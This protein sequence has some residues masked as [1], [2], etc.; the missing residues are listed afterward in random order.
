MRSLL[1]STRESQGQYQTELSKV[2]GQHETIAKLESTHLELDEI[3]NE[4]LTQISEAKV[5]SQTLK[6][7][8]D[9]ENQRARAEFLALHGEH[10]DLIKLHKTLRAQSHGFEVAITINWMR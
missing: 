10:G 3:Q 9:Q 4:L 7:H 8:Y 6:K 2:A 1:D 5:E